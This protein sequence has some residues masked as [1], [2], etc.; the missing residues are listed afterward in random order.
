MKQENY[1]SLNS[2]GLLLLGNDNSVTIYHESASVEQP[3]H[4]TTITEFPGKCA[5][6][7]KQK[8]RSVLGKAVGNV[9]MCCVFMGTGLEVGILKG[10]GWKAI[11]PREI[12]T[13]NLETASSIQ[14]F[15]IRLKLRSGGGRVLGLRSRPDRTQMIV[16]MEKLLIKPGA[17]WTRAENQAEMW[18][19]STQ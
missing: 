9:R 13:S 19:N 15:K 17:A 5:P 11:D 18:L 6:R 12:Q 2:I 4:L 14:R 16:I 10:C 8:P 3:E 1:S 7:H